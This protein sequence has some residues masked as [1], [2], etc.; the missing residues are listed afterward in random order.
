MELCEINLE[1]Y[2]LRKWPPAIVARI[3]YFADELPART[4]MSQVW[5]IMEDITDGLAF[6]HRNKEIH[7]DLKPQNGMRV[8]HL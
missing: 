3:S 8:V 2:I 7:R 1:N 5:E 4:R 6:I